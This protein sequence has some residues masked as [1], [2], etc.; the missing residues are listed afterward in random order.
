MKP[1]DVMLSKYF[2][3]GVEV[4]YNVRISKYKNIFGKGYAPNWFVIKKVKNTVLWTYII[5]DFNKEKIV[6]TFYEKE[7]TN[8]REFRI[9]K[10]IKKKDDKYVKWN[11]YNNP[12]NSWIN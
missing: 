1:I 9:E 5:E 3:F 2:N 8:Q 4:G 11:G 10:V 12:F 7:L 6:G